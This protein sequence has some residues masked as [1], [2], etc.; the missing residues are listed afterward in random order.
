MSKIIA[1]TNYV[2]ANELDNNTYP[3]G[4]QEI[5]R[6][7]EIP[8][9]DYGSDGT[10]AADICLVKANLSKRSSLLLFTHFFCTALDAFDHERCREAGDLARPR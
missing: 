3:T 9:E 7:M 1:G 4:V 2:H 8:H 10:R 6:E 5:Q